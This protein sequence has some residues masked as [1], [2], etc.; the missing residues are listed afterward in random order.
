MDSPTASRNDRL[1]ENLARLQAMVK[2]FE[3]PIMENAKPHQPPAKVID[4]DTITTSEV[5]ESPNSD[6]AC[7]AEHELEAASPA[8]WWEWPPSDVASILIRNFL[9][10]ACQVS[11]SY[12]SVMPMLTKLS[13]SLASQ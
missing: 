1:E 12:Q 2:E 11:F 8:P 13:P 9:P 3:A 4:P 5:A 7:Q 6:M 10:N